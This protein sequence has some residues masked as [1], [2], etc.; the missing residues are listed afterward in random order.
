MFEIKIKNLKCIKKYDMN[1][2]I[3]YDCN[4]M[5]KKL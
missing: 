1:E 2:I 3:L 4:M 5:N